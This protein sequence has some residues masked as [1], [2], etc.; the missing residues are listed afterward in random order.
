MMSKTILISLVLSLIQIG[1]ITAQS[2]DVIDTFLDQNKADLATSIWFVFMAENLIPD[3]ADAADAMDYF[4]DTD[5]SEK[6]SAIEP[7]RPIE[8]GEF[9]YIAMEAMDL[10]GGMM[11]AAFPSPRYASREFLYRNW[12]P[13]RPK[14]NST[15]SPWEVTSSISELIA[16]K[17]ALQ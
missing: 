6:I 12:M 13:G 8:F 11:Y 15:L 16:W 1:S 14:Q 4:L 5:F 3:D 7:D 9:A 17:E 2:N 10:P